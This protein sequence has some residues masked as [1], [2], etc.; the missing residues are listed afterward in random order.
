MTDETQDQAGVVRA[1]PY[2]AVHDGA[3]GIDFYKRAFGAV[4]AMR[5][6]EDDGRISHAE[7]RIGGVPIF[8]SD[9]YPEI[10]VLSPKSIGGS[11]V[12]I[13]L[14]VPN[15]EA[16]FQQAVT[17]GATVDRPLQDGFDGALRTA[18]IIDPFG[19]RWMILTRRHDP[20]QP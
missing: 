14:D 3:A 13:V 2:L 9:E 6:T 12:M 19:H 10:T 11:P 20:N 18:K 7:I 16:V 15:V 17:A 5:L 4:E 1:V 8:I